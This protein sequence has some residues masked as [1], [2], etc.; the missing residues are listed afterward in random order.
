MI[1]KRVLV[2]AAVIVIGLGY[3]SLGSLRKRRR[4][5]SEKEIRKGG[6]D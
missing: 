6:H 2:E 4:P 1:R 3:Q 5:N